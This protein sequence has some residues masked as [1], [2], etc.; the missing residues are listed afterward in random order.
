M[1]YLEHW[2][3][4]GDPLHKNCIH[5][6]YK[7]FAQTILLW[8][9]LFLLLFLHILVIDKELKLIIYHED[10]LLARMQPHIICQFLQ[11]EHRDS[12]LTL[13][14]V[15]Q[16]FQLFFCSLMSKMAYLGQ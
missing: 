10:I 2:A 5:M 9:K 4:K 3:G 6:G 1:V 14:F 8:H 15:W 7:L 11:C 12:L 16:R 13:Q